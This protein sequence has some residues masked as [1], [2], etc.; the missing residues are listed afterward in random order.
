MYSF[1]NHPT[2]QQLKVYLARFF[3]ATDV[4]IMTIE[5]IIKP[6][7]IVQYC[8]CLP[9]NHEAC[10]DRYCRASPILLGYQAFKIHT[11][12]DTLID[13]KIKDGDGQI[14]VTGPWCNE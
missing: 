2:L 13:G 12:I 8:L 3:L 14:C 5:L 7:I 1:E 11:F 6:R 10:T 9:P 4:T